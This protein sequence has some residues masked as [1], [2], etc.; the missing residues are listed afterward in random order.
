[1]DLS[2]LAALQGVEDV[3]LTLTD[4]VMVYM[5]IMLLFIVSYRQHEISLTR[6]TVSNQ[7]ASTFIML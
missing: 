1:M 6:K 7:E 2:K 4:L 5:R 3:I